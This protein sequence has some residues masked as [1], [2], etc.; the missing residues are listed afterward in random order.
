[1]S[2]NH[3]RETAQTRN[4]IN[5]SHNQ[6]Q[7]P[8]PTPPIRPRSAQASPNLLQW[9]Q[10]RTT[11]SQASTENSKRNRN[12]S[13][14]LLSYDEADPTRKSSYTRADPYK[15]ITSHNEAAHKSDARPAKKSV[16][17]K[18]NFHAMR[19]GAQDRSVTQW[20]N[21][22]QKYESSY[23]R[24]NS[25]QDGSVS[26]KTREEQKRENV[27]HYG[28]ESAEQ[29]QRNNKSNENYIKHMNGQMGDIGYGPSVSVR[30]LD[31]VND[32]LT[33]LTTQRSNELK[34]KILTRAPSQKPKW[35]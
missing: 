5:W 31:K 12:S 21:D 20:G 19:N 14:N 13:S 6:V 3:F 25:L 16:S 24:Y 4:V 1:M 23:K 7:K 2:H 35:R 27:L 28:Q 15:K 30:D 11:A 10:E 8:P 18:T 9:C 26:A 29:P 33:K 34:Q 22:L 17:G 32:N